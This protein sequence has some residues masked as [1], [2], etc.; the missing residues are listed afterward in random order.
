MA[1]PPYAFRSLPR[2]QFPFTI[3]AFR[4]DNGKEVWFEEVTE[5]CAVQ[6]PAL[7]QQE[8]V[9]C[10]ICLEFP[11]GKTIESRRISEDKVETIVKDGSGK[12]SRVIHDAED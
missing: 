3:R 2:E 4:E 9:Y 5:P 1:L 11:E 8:G 10:R 12:S 6:V 7:Y